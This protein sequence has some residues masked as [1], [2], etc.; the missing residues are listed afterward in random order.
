MTNLVQEMLLL[1]RA[2]ALQ[3]TPGV[4][5]IESRLDRLAMDQPQLFEV[6]K[7]DELKEQLIR[8]FKKHH[9]INREVDSKI[10]IEAAEIELFCKQQLRKN[11]KVGLAQILL[12]GSDNEIQSKVEL[13]RLA[14]EMVVPDRKS[15]V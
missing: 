14:F 10:R 12:H 6:Y 13:I 3:I 2:K 9:V 7:E 1:D 5:D 15:V 11:R 4:K 8:E